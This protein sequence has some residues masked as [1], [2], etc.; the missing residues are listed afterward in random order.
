MAADKQVKNE[1]LALSLRNFHHPV[2]VFL[3]DLA[4]NTIRTF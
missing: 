1:R 4:C 2:M 3:T